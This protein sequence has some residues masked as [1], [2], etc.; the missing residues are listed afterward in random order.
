MAITID[1][2]TAKLIPNNCKEFGRL[3]YKKICKNN[4]QTAY[5][6]TIAW[7]GPAM[8]L[9]QASLHNNQPI[10]LNAEPNPVT[11]HTSTGIAG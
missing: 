6:S 4:C 8:P 9:T 2:T 11:K 10:I 7:A 1:P 5:N 3:E